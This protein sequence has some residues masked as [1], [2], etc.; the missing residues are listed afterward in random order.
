MV[1]CNAPYKW[2]LPDLM[3]VMSESPLSI[4]IVGGGISGISAALK[5]QELLPSAQV[6]LFEKETRLG[7]VLQTQHRDGWLIEQSADMFTTVDPVAKELAERTG[8]G[9]ELIGTQPQPRQSMI[10][11][12][13]KLVPVPLGL[14][15]LAPARIWPLLTTP[16]LSMR[17][18]LRLAREPFVTKRNSEDD[19][20]LA[21]F[22]R[23]RLGTE[24]FDRL[25]QPLVGGIYTADP[26]KLSMQATLSRFVEMEK[27]AG[28]LFAGARKSGSKAD[29]KA[30]GA[31]Y[32][33][34]LAPKQGF[35]H[36]VEHLAGKLP[37][38]CRRE[39]TVKSIEKIDLESSNTKFRVRTDGND[40]TF[41]G[42]IVAT[43]SPQAGD[44]VAELDSDLA[45]KLKAIE[46]A[47]TSIVV[48]GVSNG[49]LK[50][51]ADC[52]G[53]VVP[54]IENRKII[55]AS[56]A[57][58]KFQG[59]APEGEILIRVFVG[60]ALQPELADLP[61]AELVSLVKH[62]LRE[63]IG[64]SGEPAVAEV[65][66]WTSAMPQYHLGHVERVQEIETLVAQH[67][68]LQLAGK[69]Y[70]G[71]GI[72]FCIRDGERAATKLAK[73]LACGHVAS[74]NRES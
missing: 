9:N 2:L 8:Y 11:Y 38:S 65:V 46:Y 59:R 74:A 32:S 24:V 40:E 55:A 29:R 16:L 25:I 48:L 64:L 71:V 50:H 22:T 19:E 56:F 31:R 44:L 3:K 33:A 39:A 53:F 15:L 14:S 26:E 23:R 41:D 34:F 52:Y 6:T 28:S 58:N 7:G 20:S 27:S 43:P 63:L 37:A 36:F 66:R 67:P 54:A 51:P 5:L 47:G 30:G 72:P 35:S 18:K 10:V 17:G 1:R 57:S 45:A 49:Q 42:V 61:D 4:A 62:E 73:Q 70:R 12:K 60:G 68:G 69:S 13:G 21:A